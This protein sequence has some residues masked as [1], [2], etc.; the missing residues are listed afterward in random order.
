MSGNNPL[1]GINAVPNLNHRKPKIKILQLNDAE[2]FE[3]QFN[4]LV[5]LGWKDM[6][7]RTDTFLKSNDELVSVFTA[8]FVQ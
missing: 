5:S 4:T 7:V 6:N 2:E 1:N 8:M 3:K